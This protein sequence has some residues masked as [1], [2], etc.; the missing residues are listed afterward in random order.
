MAR[1]PSG[2]SGSCASTSKALPADLDVSCITILPTYV[3]MAFVSRAATGMYRHG[4][5]PEFLGM[6]IACGSIGRQVA[7]GTKFL[8]TSYPFREP[9]TRYFHALPSG[10]TCA[11]PYFRRA[12]RLDGNH[13]GQNLDNKPALMLKQ[14]NKWKGRELLFLWGRNGSIN[15]TIWV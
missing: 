6:C 2:L 12:E 7:M 10:R 14:N 8:Q 15:F 3:S 11:R 5:S 1:R 13:K 9:I 4:S